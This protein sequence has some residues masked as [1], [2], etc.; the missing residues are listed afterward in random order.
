M[1]CSQP[2]NGHSN[3]RCKDDEK[4]LSLA[5][6]AHVKKG[7]IID[8]R[9]QQAASSHRS[10]GT[11]VKYILKITHVFFKVTKMVSLLSQ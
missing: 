6:A 3:K 8:T 4:L 5:M 1:R 2:L 10:K 11:A 7:H 9:S